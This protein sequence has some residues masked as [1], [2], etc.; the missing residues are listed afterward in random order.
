MPTILGRASPFRTP[1]DKKR[2]DAFSNEGAP[3]ARQ[4]EKPAGHPAPAPAP[5]S[6]RQRK[7]AA[8][9]TSWLASQLPRRG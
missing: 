4:P 2:E 6:E 9:F 1:F 5:L 7:S 8:K 3:P